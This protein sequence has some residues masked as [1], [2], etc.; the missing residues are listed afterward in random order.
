MRQSGGYIFIDGDVM[1][2]SNFDVV[3]VGNVGIDTNV[4]LPGSDIDFS[5]E[6]NFTE[7]FDYVGQAGGYASQGFAQL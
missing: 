5:V 6:A 7:N 4:Y 3:V 2:D 1:S